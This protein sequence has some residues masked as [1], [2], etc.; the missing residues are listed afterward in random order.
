MHSLN[1]TWVVNLLPICLVNN[2][3]DELPVLCK[4]ILNKQTNK[5]ESSG[6]M[7]PHG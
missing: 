2:K 6:K 1:L 3:G 4:I 5:Y 7:K